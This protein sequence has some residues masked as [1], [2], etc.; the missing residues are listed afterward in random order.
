MTLV[1]V[2]GRPGCIDKSVGPVVLPKF[3]S[4]RQP[5]EPDLILIHLKRGR[6][7]QQDKRSHG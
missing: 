4:F 1:V 5:N 2:G 3:G 6:P 7:F